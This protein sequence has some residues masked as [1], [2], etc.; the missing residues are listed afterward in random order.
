MPRPKITYSPVSKAGFDYWTS[1]GWAVPVPPE[2]PRDDMPGQRRGATV[3]P[4]SAGSQASG[5]GV[6]LGQRAG[7]G[8]AG[9]RGQH[10]RSI[11]NQ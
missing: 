4:G 1:K 11:A 9:T 5:T 8:R 6:A 2:S 3:A 10:K 7:D